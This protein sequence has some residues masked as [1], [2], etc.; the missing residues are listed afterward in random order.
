MVSQG[1]AMK[2]SL[3][4]G[5]CFAV[6]LGCFLR[7]QTGCLHVAILRGDKTCSIRNRSPRMMSSEG[8]NVLLLGP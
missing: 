7:V 2:F 8:I 6:V 5:I 4:R 3:V 1:R